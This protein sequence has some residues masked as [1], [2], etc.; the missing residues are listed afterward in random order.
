MSLRIS[1]NVASIN[2]QRTLTQTQDQLQRSYSQLSSGSRITK[3]GDDAAGLAI[4]ENLKSQIR[5]YLQA[6]RNAN[7]GVSLIQVAEG[8]LNEVSNILTRMR[9]LAI[10]A[11]SDTVSD[12]ERAYIDREIQQLKDEIDRIAHSTQFG[13]TPL[14]NGT[15]KEFEVQVGIFNDPT[16]DR[17]K[18]NSQE[19]NSTT[20]ALGIRGISYL[21]KTAAQASLE[22]I[23]EALNRVSSQRAYLGALQN[24]FQSTLQNLAIQNENLN[25]ANSR[26][27][28][29]D[30][31]ASSAEAAKNNILLQSS[32]AVLAQANQW[33]AIALKLLS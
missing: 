21:K 32:T 29:T 11:A 17:L 14:L 3:A 31:A 12:R 23:D 18:F 30:F 27:R 15:G 5:S 6:A 16:R 1:T 7:D 4:S 20:A 2:A 8:G 19:L 25:A 26:I 22:K 33:P 9:E 10:Q 13:T 28:D 24:R